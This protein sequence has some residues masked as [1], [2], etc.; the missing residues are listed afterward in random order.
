MNEYKKYRDIPN[1]PHFARFSII[2]CMLKMVR[3]YV[4]FSSISIERGLGQLL[5]FVGI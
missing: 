5:Y 3:L 2:T 1:F 4:G